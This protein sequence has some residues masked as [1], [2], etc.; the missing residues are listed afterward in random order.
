LDALPQ[1]NSPGWAA[2]CLAPFGTTTRQKAIPGVELVELDLRDDASVKRAIEAIEAIIDKAERI[3]VLVN[4][5]GGTMVGSVEE[6]SILEAQALFDT[7]VFDTNVFGT[8]RTTQAVL[9]H[10]RQQRSG[11]IIN[12]SSVS[13]GW[14]MRRTPKGEASMLNKLRRFMPAGPVDGGLRKTF[15]LV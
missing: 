9:P 11:R 2:G 8:L 15:G 12:V 10:M 5:A 1:S 6:T 3:D 7:N 14:K 4:N 13:S